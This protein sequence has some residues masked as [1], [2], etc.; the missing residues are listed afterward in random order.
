[1][2]TNNPRI[3]ITLEP[4]IANLISSLAEQEHKSVSSFAKELLLEALDRRE[5]MVLS[6]I[7]ENRDKENQPTI[8]HSDAWK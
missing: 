6:S 1:M 5:D 8:S 2:P 3:N 4:E 7:A